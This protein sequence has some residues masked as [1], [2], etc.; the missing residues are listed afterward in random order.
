MTHVVHVERVVVGTV[1]K[2]V[3]THTAEVLR[4]VL[5]ADALVQLVQTYEVA[6]GLCH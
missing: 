6:V 5:A 3:G 1:G 4:C 2:V